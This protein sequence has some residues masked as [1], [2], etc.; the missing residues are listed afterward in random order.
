MRVELAMG[1]KKDN[2]SVSR[3]VQTPWRD[4]RSAS[5]LTLDIKRYFENVNHARLVST[6]RRLGFPATICSWLSSFLS[7]RFVSFSIDSSVCQP[8]PLAS[9][10]PILSSIYSRTISPY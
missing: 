10:S 7:D 9:L 8:A 3:D 6:Y 1:G 4:K 5:L 2:Y